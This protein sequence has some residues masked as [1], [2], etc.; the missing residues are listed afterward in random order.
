MPLALQP[1]LLRV[2]EDGSMR[3]I[4]SHKER[5]VHVRLITATNRNLAEEVKQN[6][7]RE[8]LLPSERV[9]HS[10][11]T[12]SRA[13]RRCRS[14]HRSFTPKQW[15]IDS[16]ARRAMNAYHWPGNVRELINVIQRATILADGH[17]ITIDDLP[18]EIAS[19][20]LHSTP[21]SNAQ[22]DSP[23]APSDL[24][25]L[26]DMARSHILHVLKIHDGNK[27]QAARALGIHR[28]K[29]YRLLERL[30]PPTNH[31]PFELAL[32]LCS[33]AHSGRKSV[34]VPHIFLWYGVR[35]VW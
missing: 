17:E 13:S 24:N 23:S 11:A 18:L 26:D 27:A 16:E 14:P 5:R 22:V 31:P 12:S 34:Q 1:K 8:D 30:A 7:F 9:A 4:G 2:L 28:R 19:P 25:R 20:F 10:I 15:R 29:L 35:R 21:L 33:N 6:R 32:P 3:R